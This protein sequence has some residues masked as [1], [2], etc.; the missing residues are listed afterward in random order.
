MAWNRGDTS[1][2]QVIRSETGRVT[3]EILDG[4]NSGERFTL[5]PQQP[6]SGADHIEGQYGEG[7]EA[8]G[9]PQSHQ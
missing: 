3:V 5:F 6:F 1:T 8:R 9:V 2:F 7:G 4:A